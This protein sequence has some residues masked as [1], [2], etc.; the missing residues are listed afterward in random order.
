MSSSRIT[1]WTELKSQIMATVFQRRIL[2]D[3]VH[4][5]EINCARC[6]I[7]H[8]LGLKHHTSKLRTFE[9]LERV[10][11]FGFRGEALHA[12]CVLATLQITTATKDDAPKGTKLEFEHSGKLKSQSMVPFSKGTSVYVENLFHT[13]PVRRQELARKIKNEYTKVLQLLQAY[14]CVS[15]GVRFNVTNQPSKGYARS[16]RR[17]LVV[18]Y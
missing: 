9:D 6:M 1:D 10:D 3:L 7:N 16:S 15:T 18:P 13:L 12:M 14:A 8:F 2:R 4:L 17:C 11:T 5:S